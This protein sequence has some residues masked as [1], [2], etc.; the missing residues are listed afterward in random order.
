LAVR[1]TVAQAPRVALPEALADV[2]MVTRARFGAVPATAV[3]ATVVRTD[4]VTVF[5]T[6]TRTL[7]EKCERAAAGV[8]NRVANNATT[9]TAINARRTKTVVCDI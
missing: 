8:A 7:A 1:R 6:C 3:A 9:A 4:L 5:V 2:R